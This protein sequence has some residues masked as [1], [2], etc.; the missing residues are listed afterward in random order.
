M[1]ESKKSIRMKIFKSHMIVIIISAILIFLS[2]NGILNYYINSQTKKELYVAATTIQQ[3]IVDSSNGLTTLKNKLVKEK[4]LLDID[5]SLIGANKKIIFPIEKGSSEYNLT[6][7]YILNYLDKKNILD[8]SNIKNNEFNFSIAS[9][10]YF[11]IVIPVKVNNKNNISYLVVYSDVVKTKG[12]IE[13]VNIFLFIIL[14]ITAIITAFISSNLSKKISMPI[15]NLIE[16][17]ENI[18]ERKYDV[19]LE[20]NSDDEIAILGETMSEMVLKLQTYDNAMKAFLQNASH[21]MRTP[22]MSIQGYAEG[23]KY[24]VLEDNEKATDIIIEE[25]K[26]LTGIVEDLL[27]LS[28]LEVMQENFSTE[29]VNLEVMLRSS[30]DR[31]NGIAVQAEKSIVF[32]K[33]DRIIKSEDVSIVGDEEKLIRAIINLLGNCLRYCKNEILVKL[34]KIDSVIT[35]TVEDDGKGFDEV[36]LGKIFQRFYK[37]KGGKYGLGLTISKSIIERHG[38]QIYAENREDGGARFLIKCY[39]Q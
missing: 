3:S 13:I 6:K 18:G 20:N 9:R 15:V 28:R 26:R 27:L 14:G 19:K 35:I 8:S 34:D 32:L 1:R 24:H 4:S 36:E 7:D 17:A 39:V 23:I 2:F 12:F 33:S 29:E 37:G 30:I 11:A 22:L 31:V 25:S 5:F 38:G 16:Y 10:K 21:E